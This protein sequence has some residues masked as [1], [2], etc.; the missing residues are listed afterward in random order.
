MKLPYE[1]R[2]TVLNVEAERF[3]RI[4]LIEEVKPVL[5]ELQSR[6]NGMLSDA[7]TSSTIQATLYD[8]IEQAARLAKRLETIYEL[9]VPRLKLETVPWHPLAL[10]PSTRASHQYLECHLQLILSQDCTE[11]SAWDKLITVCGALDLHLSRNVFKR[12]IDGEAIYMAT[13]RSHTAAPAAFTQRVEECKNVLTELNS[14]EY[15]TEHKLKQTD[16][17]H[18]LPTQQE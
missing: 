17:I 16:V 11:G 1:I 2:A 10:D 9:T 4:C 5:L 13:V 12:T 3:Q 15:H 14:P 7:M 6:T 18:G 8:A